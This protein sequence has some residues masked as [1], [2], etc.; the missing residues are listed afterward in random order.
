MVS[1]PSPKPTE[2]QQKGTRTKITKVEYRRK[3]VGNLL[4]ASF[5]LVI[6]FA[7]ILYAFQ[8]K[9]LIQVNVPSQSSTISKTF[10]TNLAVSPTFSILGVYSNTLFVFNQS[11]SRI[12]AYDATALDKPGQEIAFVPNFNTFLWHSTGKL[13][14]SSNAQ[15]ALGNIYFLDLSQSI[16][17]SA[18]TQTKS[19]LITDREDAPHFLPN[20]QIEDSLPL[21]WSEN[22]DAI[23]FVARDIN[24]SKEWLMIYNLG[25]LQFTYTPAHS[26]ESIN[27]LV[28]VEDTLTFVGIS[29]GREALYWVDISGGNFSRWPSP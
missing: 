22:G 12:Y 2:S 13:L 23:A 19:V 10:T 6:L 18:P 5:I 9:P 3:L 25:S 29:N 7:G 11:V 16:T 28:W 8:G 17:Q 20:L 4:L 27:S 15:N 14:F 24:D 1:T 26:M 21:I